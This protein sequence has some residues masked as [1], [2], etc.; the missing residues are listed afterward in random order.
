LAACVA[1]LPH[2]LVI[3]L[4][5][6]DMASRATEDPQVLAAQ[7]ARALQQED[8]RR[9]QAL[10]ERLIAQVPDMAEAYSNLGYVLY[11]QGAYAPAEERLD[12]A[13]R[14]NPNLGRATLLLA[15]CYFD[16]NQLAKAVP[17]LE[18]V[19]AESDSGSAVAQHLALAYLHLQ[20]FEKALVPL[21]RWLQLEPNNPDAL[22][23][24]GRAHFLLGVESYSRLEKVAPDSFRV[25]QMKAELFQ[26]QE[27][28]EAAIAEYRKAIQKAPTVAGLHFALA[29]LLWEH[30]RT[31]EALEEYFEERK[32]SPNDPLTQYK[33]GNIRLQQH[34]Y[35]AARDELTRAVTLSAQM[36]DAHRDLSQVFRAEGNLDKSVEEIRKAMELEPDRAELHYILFDIYRQ[37][38]QKREAAMELAKFQELK[39]AGS[40]EA[41]GMGP[42]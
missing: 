39:K 14:L 36:A 19:Y 12:R 1:A 15:L 13:L 11:M 35:P 26:R 6:S 5:C 28:T 41:S 37:R 10:Y 23:Y 17:L 27:Q 29:E 31:G 32:L 24:S 8:F 22:Y 7:A 33:I 25:H 40:G 38:G 16:S 4:V 3:L 2:L 30:K 21:S 18:K 20:Q 42:R 34:D 9:A